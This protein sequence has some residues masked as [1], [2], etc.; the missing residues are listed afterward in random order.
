MMD[1]KE[2]KN[3]IIDYLSENLSEV[4]KHEFES[5][6]KV[7]PQHREEFDQMK[8]FWSIE[9]STPEPSTAMDVKFYTMLNAEEQK[10][11]SVSLLKRIETFLLGS[12]TKQLA[13]T[14][15]ILV[16]GFFIGKQMTSSSGVSEDSIKYAQKET[17]NVRSQLVLALLEQPSANKRLQAVNEANK[18]NEVT[19]TI[20]KALFSTLNNDTNV[21]VRL[22]AVEALGN[23]TDIPIVREGL[24]A[25]ISLQKA[26]LVQIALAD[27]MVILQEKK[28]VK[29]FKKLIEKEDVNESAKEKMKESIQQII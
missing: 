4:K 1:Y 14:V 6:L 8:S 17:E 24:I 28:A 23:Y 26:P 3:T 20:I 2:Y 15:V 18:L 13:Y 25:S 19:E 11:E 29:S 7:N 16:A 5:F 10:K 27:L 21:N 9:E 22:S 12:V